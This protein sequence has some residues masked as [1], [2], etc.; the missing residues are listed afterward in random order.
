[1][2]PNATECRI[3]EIIPGSAAEK[4]GLQVNDVIIRFDGQKLE[5]REDLQLL[6]GGKRPGDEVT[7]E[8]RRDDQTLA[9]KVTLGRR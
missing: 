5:K 6:I 2:D 1:M 4:A 7:L 8:V 9:L 3:E